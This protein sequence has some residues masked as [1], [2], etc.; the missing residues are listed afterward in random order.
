MVNNY[1]GIAR[2]YRPIKRLIFGEQLDIASSFFF[3]KIGAHEHIL[4]VGGGSGEILRNIP[5]DVNVTYIEKSHLMIRYAKR[6]ESEN[7]HFHCGDFLQFE[8]AKKFDSIV[9]P[10]FLDVFNRESLDAAIKKL[11]TLL[12]SDGKLHVCDFQKGNFFQNIFIGF[13]YLFFKITTNIQVGT[14]LD[15]HG[16]ILNHE[17]KELD[18]RLF[19]GGIVFSRFYT[20]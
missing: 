5:A 6:F 1:D 11:S 10:F 14:L 13:M 17:F 4:I 15:I 2:I 18:S 3:N 16:A 8:S 9:C 7:V 19:V 20:M 12:C